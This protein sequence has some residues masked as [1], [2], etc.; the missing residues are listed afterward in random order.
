MTTS[1]SKTTKVPPTKAPKTGDSTTPVARIERAQLAALLSELPSLGEVQRK[2]FLRQFSDESCRALGVTT[3]AAVVELE[4]MRFARLAH[5]FL[6]GPAAAS[7]RYAPARLA[8]LLE[9][10]DALV[11]AREAD[12]AARGAVQAKQR[13]RTLAAERA[14]SLAGELSLALQDA[15]VGDESLA[16]ELSDARSLVTP[17][18]DAAAALDALAGVLES[19]LKRGDATLAALLDGYGLSTQDVAA[20][21]DAASSL[22]AERARAQGGGNALTDGAEVNVREGRVLYELRLLRKLFHRASD[23]LG[24]PTIPRF[25]PSPSL[26]RV[27][28]DER[29]STEGQPEAP[30]PTPDKG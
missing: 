3:R 9:C 4:A 5:G 18:D 17:A 13:G 22:R 10:L 30:I 24:D 16:R 23:R 26:R 8:W 29:K 2:A 15:A 19:W 14:T 6:R 27:F 20:A 11:G 28:I 7:V 1:R 25:N 12:V 21:R